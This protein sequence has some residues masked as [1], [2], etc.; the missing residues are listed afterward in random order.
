MYLFLCPIFKVKTD[1]KKKKTDERG[2][3]LCLGH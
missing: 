1:E 2:D 3:V